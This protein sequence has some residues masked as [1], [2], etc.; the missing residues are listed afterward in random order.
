MSSS[1]YDNVNAIQH[2][3]T[4]KHRSALTYSC[5]YK[6]KLYSISCSEVALSKF[7]NKRYYVSNTHSLQYGH[8][9][10]NQPIQFHVLN[11]VE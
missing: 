8:F 11:I 6:H 3:F 7:E 2:G 5:I 1:L 9:A 4:W 10:M